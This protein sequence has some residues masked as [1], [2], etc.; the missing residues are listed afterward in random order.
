MAAIRS[1]PATLTCDPSPPRAPQLL[2][3]MDGFQQNAGVIVLAATVREASRTPQ[4]LLHTR[5][6]T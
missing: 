5:W 3:E 4:T 6:L 1:C 2:V